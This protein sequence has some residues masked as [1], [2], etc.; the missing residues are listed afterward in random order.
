MNYLSGSTYNDLLAYLQSY[1]QSNNT[2]YASQFV[3]YFGD[4]VNGY[5]PCTNESGYIAWLSTFLEDEEDYAPFIAWDTP[6]GLQSNQ[7]GGGFKIT[8]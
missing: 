1:D 5:Y 8:F 7:G 2:S 6:T 4:P 3:T